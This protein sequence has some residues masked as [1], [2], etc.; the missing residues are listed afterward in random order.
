MPV[1]T[2]YR[3]MIFCKNH[4]IINYVRHPTPPPDPLTSA[5]VSMYGCDEVFDFSEIKFVKF[6]MEQTL[7]L[8]QTCYVALC[9]HVL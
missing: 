4:L 3:Y 1:K 2:V 8:D 7:L 5:H 6:G 9:G